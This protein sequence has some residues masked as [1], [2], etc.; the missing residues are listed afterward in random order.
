MTVVALQ[1]RRPERPSAVVGASA[2]QDALDDDRPLSDV[3]LDG[4][5]SVLTNRRV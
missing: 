3:G 4:H 5:D 1:R 2:R